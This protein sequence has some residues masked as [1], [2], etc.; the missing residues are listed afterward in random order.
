[1]QRKSEVVDRN[2]EVQLCAVFHRLS[3]QLCGRFGD[4][5]DVRYQLRDIDIFWRQPGAKYVIGVRH[6]FQRHPL[7]IR[8]RGFRKQ[9]HRFARIQFHHVQQQRREEAAVVRVEL[10]N[11]ANGLPGFPLL[12]IEG[13]FQHRQRVGFLVILHIQ[14]AGKQLA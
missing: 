9:E 4:E 2:R 11:Q 12:I 1:M 10:R 7:Q 8:M 6:H 3:Q 14:Q 5:F 13:G